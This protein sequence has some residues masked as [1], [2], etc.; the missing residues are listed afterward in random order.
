MPVRAG[1]R[2]KRCGAARGMDEQP[3]IQER[4]W[5]VNSSVVSLIIFT[6]RRVF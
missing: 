3:H 1:W 5:V 4:E 6:C 2:L